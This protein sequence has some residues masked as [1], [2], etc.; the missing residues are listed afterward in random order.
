MMAMSKRKVFW[1]AL[2]TC[3]SCPGLPE[4][5][6]ENG[7]GRPRPHASYRAALATEIVCSGKV[8][9]WRDI[10]I[11][12]PTRHAAVTG[13]CHAGG[14][15]MVFSY[16]SILHYSTCRAVIR[17]DCSGAV[18]FLPEVQ[19]NALVLGEIMAACNNNNENNG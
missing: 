4:V 7:R 3:M 17:A 9:A 16:V 6:L 19:V 1:S 11:W 10:L 15:C 18:V 14:C 12:K 2:E 5:E 13:A 8:S